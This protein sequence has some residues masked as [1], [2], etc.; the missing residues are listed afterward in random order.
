MKI[1]GKTLLR[2]DRLFWLPHRLSGF[3]S[4]VFGKIHKNESNQVLLIKFMGL[5][6]IIHLSSLCNKNNVDRSRVMLLT[7]EA[8]RPLCDLIGFSNTRFV[9]TNGLLVFCKDCVRILLSMRQQR[10][11]LII[12]YER[13]SHAVGFFR[14]L[15]GLIAQSKTLSFEKERTLSTEKRVIYSIKDFNQEE[16]FLKGI[17]FLPQAISQTSVR[18]VESNPFKILININAS[19]Y[20]L[21]RRYSI[22]RFAEVIRELHEWNPLLEFYLTGSTE[23]KSYVELLEKQLTGL[24][25]KNVTGKWDLEKLQKE[26]LTSSLFITCDSGPLHLA[27][28]L[29]ASTIAVW[30]PT[31]PEHFGY[32]KIDHLHN[33]SLRLR[34]A[35]CFKHPASDPAYACHGRIDCLKELSS[36]IITNKAKHILSSKQSDSGQQNALT[37]TFGEGLSVTNDVKLFQ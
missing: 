17:E 30:G 24:P 15:L 21:A 4:N 27:V 37:S 19:N 25:I 1:T 35:P 9:R 18:K 2:I 14:T 31:Q 20:L 3:L 36:T 34:C 11:A 5:G 33:I 8:N 10:P 12:D 6:S 28:E 29:G 7:L 16:L 32:E 26:L 22:D 13:C 23:E